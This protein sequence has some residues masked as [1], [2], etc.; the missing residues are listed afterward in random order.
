[1]KLLTTA[2]VGLNA[3]DAHLTT[4]LV[5]SGVGTELNP[6]V[7]LFLQRGD[8]WLWLMKGVGCAISLAIFIVLLKHNPKAA[9][10]V[11]T[12][13]VSVLYLVCMWN[14]MQAVIV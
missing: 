1:M 5:G 8:G 10:R 6:F 11:L 7:N 3:L 13:C 9:K 2:Y 12:I 14:L 4:Q